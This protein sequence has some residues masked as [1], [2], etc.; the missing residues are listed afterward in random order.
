MKKFLYIPLM[1]LAA[2]FTSSLHA[3]DI[4]FGTLS[5]TTTTANQTVLSYTPPSTEALKTI[6]IDYFLTSGS[7]AGGSIGTVAVQLNGVTKFQQIV[8]AAGITSVGATDSTPGHIVIP[9]GDGLIF[10]GTDVIKIVVTPNTLTT[11]TVNASL[12]LQ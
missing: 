11:Q 10:S 9:L 3:A 12:F 7:S 4:Q 5:P 6:A 8:Y 1:C 2:A